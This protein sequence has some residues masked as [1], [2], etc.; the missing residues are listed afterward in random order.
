MN[1]RP[2]RR[3]RESWPSCSF[4]GVFDGHGGSECSNFLRDHL[5]EYVTQ[6][7]WFPEEPKKAL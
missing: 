7:F 6:N 2:Y 4:F 3:S 1:I 5:H